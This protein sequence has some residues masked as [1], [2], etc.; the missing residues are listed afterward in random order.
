MPLQ[1]FAAKGLFSLHYKSVPHW[2]P[3]SSPQEAALISHV[4][5]ARILWNFELLEEHS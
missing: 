4:Q 5:F 3:N 2:Y 1:E